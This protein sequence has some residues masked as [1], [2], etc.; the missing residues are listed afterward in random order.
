MIMRTFVIGHLNPDTD[1]IV[2]A[3]AL[4]GLL[5]S[6]GKEARAVK[7]GNLNKESQWA[8][9]HCQAKDS[10]EE[11]E[12]VP[13]GQEVFFVDF[14]E[15]DQCPLNPEKVKLI[16]LLDHHKLGSGWKTEEPI[17][18]RVE[19]VGATSTLMAKIYREKN[20][21][22]PENLAKLLLC[23]I[24]SDTLN[25]TSPTTTEEDK[26]WAKKLSEQTNEN[27][28]E[29]ANNLFEAKSD[30]S[31]FT[32]EEVAKLDYKVFNFIGKKIGIGV[33]ETVRSDNAKELEGELKK[34]M[35]KIK[36]EEGLDYVYLGIVD[37]LNNQTEL[38]IG[39]EETKLLARKA[40]SEA[41]ESG[42]NLILPNIVSRKK[43]IAPAIERVLK[44][45]N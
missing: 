41:T 45:Q 12:N 43:Q 15:F 7:K 21:P 14:N 10:I 37:I 25:L 2:S 35:G 44:M 40:F 18:F 38:L 33:I 16:G 4:A 13:D 1:S 22:L 5:N 24:I 23:G 20:I 32:P 8:L 42:D 28:E 31:S 29:L 19:P 26:H 3:I 17:L 30:L 34:V 39:D 9:D 36:S 11:L 27:V 6:E